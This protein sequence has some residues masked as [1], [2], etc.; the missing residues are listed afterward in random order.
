[1]IIKAKRCFRKWKAA[2]LLGGLFLLFPCVI[3]GIYKLS[4]VS[5]ILKPGDLL[6]YYGMVFGISGPL[7]LYR[8][9]Q[10]NA[11]KKRKTELKPSFVVDVTKLSNED[12]FS[13]FI[14][15]CSTGR[16]SHFGLYDEYVVADSKKEYT[17]R[18]TYFQPTE[19]VKALQPDFNMAADDDIMGKDGFPKY[20]QILCDDVEGN[21]WNC[22]YD[23]IYNGEQAYY[24]PSEIEI[25]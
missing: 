3:A 6:S 14:K 15:Q 1:M 10:K 13:I 20:V 25:L 11:E 8:L 12:V 24:Y 17:L 16:L 23:R 19:R 5:E 18:V 9:E 4:G 7:L 21:T 2:L 22:C